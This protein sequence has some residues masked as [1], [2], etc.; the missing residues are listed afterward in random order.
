MI[1][2]PWETTVNGHIRCDYSK[3]VTIE[4]H[5]F[6]LGI[7]T[8]DNEQQ[9]DLR[10]LCQI[11]QAS[12]AFSAGPRHRVA[13]FD[14]R[15]LGIVARSGRSVRTAESRNKANS[16]LD[17]GDTEDARTKTLRSKPPS[18][19]SD[20]RETRERDQNEFHTTDVTKEARIY[21]PKVAEHPMLKD[22]E[23]LSSIR[24]HKSKTCYDPNGLWY[25]YM[26]IKNN[27]E[28]KPCVT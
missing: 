23:N 17:D 8:I 11:G 26:K 14:A 19:Y 9:D 25:L 2:I 21:D 13:V 20:L 4:C 22:K 7:D 15:L 6:L 27:L 10:P 1:A 16:R 28:M 18:F 12:Q 5:K 24:P 3:W